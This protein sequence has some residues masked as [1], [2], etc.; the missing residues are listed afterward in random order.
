MMHWLRRLA[1]RLSKEEGSLSTW[2]APALNLAQS[3]PKLRQHKTPI[4]G[5]PD[6]PVLLPS[7]D[8]AWASKVK[9]VKRTCKLCRNSDNF[10]TSRGM[11]TCRSCGAVEDI[12][13]ND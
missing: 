6:M 12:E 5:L 2:T 3:E 1:G 7:I 4:P 13:D 8:G 9:P 10:T 11:S